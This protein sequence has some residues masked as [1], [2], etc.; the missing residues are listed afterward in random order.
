MD[1][2]IHYIFGSMRT[3][4]RNFAI[5][6]KVLK[7]QSKI[8]RLFAVQVLCLLG[9][10]YFNDRDIRQLNKRIKTLE[11]EKTENKGA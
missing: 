8:N 9:L 5:I 11:A 1:E 2:M 4:N 10:C 6:E 3:Y 7:N